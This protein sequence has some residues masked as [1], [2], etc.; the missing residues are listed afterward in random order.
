MPCATGALSAGG[1]SFSVGLARLQ[2]RRGL[3]YNRG[4]IRI[5]PRRFICGRVRVIEECPLQTEKIRVYVL[6]RELN[7]DTKILLDMCKQAGYDVKN[8]LSNLEPE[9]RDAIVAPHT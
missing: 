4:S 9:H 3:G 7:V 8:Q 1:A 6:A 2:K 5:Y